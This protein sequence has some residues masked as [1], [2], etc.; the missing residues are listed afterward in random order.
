MTDQIVSWDCE[1]PKFR[2]GYMAPRIVCAST[3]RIVDGAIR[4]ELLA[5]SQL[6]LERFEALLD[7]NYT[8]ALANASY[9]L[10]VAAAANMRLLA[11]IFK[12]LREGRIH[13]ILLAEGLN[14]IFGGHHGM[15]PDG[16][17]MRKVGDNGAPGKVTTRYGLEIVHKTLTGKVD[18]KANDVWQESYAIVEP[19]PV[20]KWPPASR[21][22]PVNDSDN[23]LEDARIQRRGVKKHAWIESAKETSCHHCGE[24]LT[25]SRA[26]FECPAA[27]P[28]PY[29]N[30]QNLPKQVEFAFAQQ[31]GACW[32]F[33]TDPEKVDA[34]DADVEEKHRKFVERFQ[35]KG[36]IRAD[37]T[38]D[39]AAVKR[40]IAFAYG[41]TGA[42]KRCKG[43]VSCKWCAG[44]GNDG[45]GNC[46]KCD[47][48][49]THIGKIQKWD[50]IECRGEKVRGRFQGCTWS[51]CTA[52]HGSGKVFKIGNVV[53][54]KNVF[55]EQDDTL[56]LEEGCDGT[57]LDLSTASLLRR[58]EKLGVATDRDTAM[59]S[60]DEDVSDYGENEFEKSRNT[61]VPYLRE[62]TVGPLFIKTNALV[63][64]GRCSYEG[65][66][67]HQFPR[68]GMERECI[69]ARGAWCGCPVEYVLGSTDYSAGELCTLAQYTYWLF[70]ESRMRDVINETGD[71]GILHSVLA[72]EVLGLPLDEFL[73]RLKAK[74]K[75]AALVR[76]ASK[77]MNFGK[78]AGMSAAKIVLTNRK[79]SV[80]FTVCEGGPAR[81]RKGEPGYWGI[82]F[83]ITVGGERACGVEKIMEWNKNPTAPVCKACCEAVEHRLTPAYF[84]R[85]PE[86]KEYHRW[87]K[88]M[89]KDRQPVP[90][91]VWNRER[92][93]IEIVRER[94]FLDWDK[95]LP[96]LLNNGFQSM[97]A[98]I[99]KDAFVTAT[100]ECYLGVKDDGS[101][102][103]L[104]GCRLPLFAHDEPVSELILDTAHLSGPRIAEIMME[105]GRKFAPDVTWKAETALAF[106]WNKSMDPKYV[107]GK[108]VPWGPIPDYL[109]ERL[110]A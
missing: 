105:S 102:S 109:R 39:Q 64:T 81:N 73:A 85:F 42:C 97:L 93:E 44:T 95:E 92:G 84:R 25:F 48:I 29:R 20:E 94:G 10:A 91:V 28:E 11:K 7:A 47:G 4:G 41:A 70:S 66:P 86:I 32:S 57:G 98:D 65:C 89:I 100:R 90:S 15:E 5:G 50:E 53:T 13:D 88:Q 87:G 79:K 45:S 69:R 14:A 83:C 9:D 18:A 101:P 71:P 72:A 3:S 61:Y 1:T 21:I 56:M 80:G 75:E 33:R 106:W 54:C 17:S 26:S 23:T 16:S 107:A 19:F 99:G 58:T 6:A 103:P 67:V 35:K 78:P 96:A 46:R 34:L 76:Q 108:L 40:A 38:E 104:A 49:G 62:G 110:A 12:A 59:E 30:Q 60:G 36:W 31:L 77:P 68:E 74:D 51:T 43:G 2:A 8:I 22:Y 37:G 82:R 55:D 63:A 52:C 24:V 27:P